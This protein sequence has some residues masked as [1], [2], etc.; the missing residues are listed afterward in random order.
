MGALGAWDCTDIYGVNLHGPLLPPEGLPFTYTPFAALVFGPLTWLP[1][2]S[3]VTA[4]SVL[5]VVALAA[6]MWLMPGGAALPG[7]TGDA[8]PGPAAGTPDNRGVLRRGRSEPP[9]VRA[10]RCGA[11][12]P[13]SLLL[14]GVTL[15]VWLYCRFGRGGASPAERAPGEVHDLATAG[16]CRA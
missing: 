9:G 10:D 6:S 13:E 1:V 14:C 4:W 3:G 2:P 11:H 5:T 12:G 16:P 8:V 15:L 7:G